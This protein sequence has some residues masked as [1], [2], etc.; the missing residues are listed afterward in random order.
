M[1]GLSLEAVFIIV[2]IVGIIA[3]YQKISDIDKRLY[4]IFLVTDSIFKKQAGIKD[5]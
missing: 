3:I 4:S 2:V 5:D 1:H